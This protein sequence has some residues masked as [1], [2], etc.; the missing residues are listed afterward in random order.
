MLS[1]PFMLNPSPFMLSLS[2]REGHG[3]KGP[4]RL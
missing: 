2:K 1:H 3:P 4:Y